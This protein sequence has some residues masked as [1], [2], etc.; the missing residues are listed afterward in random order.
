MRTLVVGLGNRFRGD[1][2]AGPAVVD[3]LV[4]THVMTTGGDPLGV[5]HTWSDYDRV[6]LVDA[7]RS[8]QPVGT[9]NWLD[10]SQ[11]LPQNASYSST[12]SL[13]PTELV[14]LARVLDCVP[15]RLEVVGIEASTFE[16]GAELSPAVR[17]A[18][19]SVAEELRNA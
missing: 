3:L 15:D 13:G 1:D 6:V 16:M 9:I 10:A 4:D 18:T 2:G 11:D 19:Y 17:K 14:G 8:G 12:H 5:I 7:M